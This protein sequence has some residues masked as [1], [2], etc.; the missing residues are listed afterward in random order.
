MYDCGCASV[1]ALAGEGSPIKRKNK[2]FYGWVIVA[3]IGAAGF[4][5][6]GQFNPTIGVFIKPITEEFAWDRKTFAGAN[7][8][9]TIAGGLTAVFIGPLL[10][11]Y[12]PRWL[13][14]VGFVVVGGSLAALSQTSALWHF[15]VAV[16]VGRVVVQGVLNLGVQVTTPMWFVRKRGQAI[17]LSGMGLRFGNGLTPVYAQAILAASNWRLA[18]LSVGIVAWVVGFLPSLLFLR[19]RPEDMGLRPDGDPGPPRRGPFAETGRRAPET[20]REERSYTLREAA[21]TRPFYVL[22][23][24]TTLT[25][26]VG[27]AVNFHL[28]AYLD[29]QGVDPSVGTLVLAAWAAFTLAGGLTTGF[30]ADRFPVKPLLAAAYAG[31]AASLLLL[32]EVTSVPVAFMW[33]AAYGITFGANTTLHQL[34]WPV[35]FGRD[36]L[37]AIRGVVTAFNMTSNAFGPLA[38]AFVFDA[39]G[40]YSLIWWIS[41]ITLAAVAGV[42]LVALSSRKAAGAA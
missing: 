34:V 1:A 33:A 24:V 20:A 26:F 16:I 4:A 38:A 32:L 11:R 9:G 5:M 17:A 10:D 25:F 19:R 28:I 2:L 30:I 37:G 29:D 40:S 41:A 15:Y 18:M 7:T 6:A 21:S 3:V 22:L 27:A 35:Y 8:I 13:M 39:T 42:T 14:T 36:A 31:L 23:A 12:G